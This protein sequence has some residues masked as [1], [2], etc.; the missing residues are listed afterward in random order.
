MGPSAAFGAC[1]EPLPA[2]ASLLL[3]P[4]LLCLLL[5]DALPLE[6]LPCLD[7]DFLLFFS[8]RFE[9]LPCFA[10]EDLPALLTPPLAFKLPLWPPSRASLSAASCA[11]N[12]LQNRHRGCAAHTSCLAPRQVCM[13]T[14][15]GCADMRCATGSVAFARWQLWRADMNHACM[16]QPC[17]L[18]TL[19]Y[20][21]M[22]AAS[23]GPGR[24]GTAGNLA[25]P[26][27]CCREGHASTLL[28]CL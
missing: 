11:L 12:S 15:G 24:L 9:S 2:S 16:A 28:Q 13:A 17:T 5:L 7:L 23:W 21:G 14:R 25:P 18:A 10:F 6:S 20:D 3:L 27:A 4:L 1:L 19:A 8:F 22:A 26:S